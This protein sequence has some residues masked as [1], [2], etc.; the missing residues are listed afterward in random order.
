MGL[1]LP[2]QFVRDHSAL[3]DLAPHAGGDLELLRK[4]GRQAKWLRPIGCM[5][6][7]EVAEE[8]EDVASAKGWE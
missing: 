3:L 5:L 2:R 1:D 8:K 7:H 6:R 4:L